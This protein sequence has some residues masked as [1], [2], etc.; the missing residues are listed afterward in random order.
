M[1]TVKLPYISALSTVSN[2]IS[3]ID[4]SKHHSLTFHLS[5]PHTHLNLYINPHQSVST[6]YQLKQM[7]RP[8]MWT[9]LH[10]NSSSYWYISLHESSIVQILYSLLLSHYPSPLY[11]RFLQTWS[12]LWITLLISTHRSLQK[13]VDGSD[14]TMSSQPLKTPQ[15]NHIVNLVLSAPENM[16]D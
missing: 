4:S 3:T 11:H 16:Q 2:P 5:H 8:L 15:S 12:T 9:Q 10:K 7:K 14:A 13:N 6:F 1:H